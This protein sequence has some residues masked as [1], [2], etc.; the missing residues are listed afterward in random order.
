MKARAHEPQHTAWEAQAREGAQLQ[1]R[2]YATLVLEA[3][4]ST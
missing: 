2:V 3:T 4:L 1:P